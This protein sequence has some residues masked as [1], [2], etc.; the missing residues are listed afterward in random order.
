MKKL[1]FL[2][3]LLITTVLISCKRDEK[4][5]WDVDVSAPIANTKLSIAN[6][7]ADSLMTVN[8]DH[9]VNICYNDTLNTM[10]FGSVFHLPDTTIR[11]NL[12]S[13][14]WTDVY[15]GQMMFYKRDKVKFKIS[16]ASVSTVNVRSGKIVYTIVSTLKQK[17]KLTYQ[18]T[19]ASKNGKLLNFTTYLLPNGSNTGS[20]ISGELDLSDYSFNFTG[21]G[22]STNQL[23]NLITASNDSASN[24]FEITPEDSIS[25]FITFKDVIPN[26]A[27][28]YFGQI[29]DFSGA[30]STDLSVFK[31]IIA[32]NIRVSDIKLSLK[33]VNYLGVDAR[34]IL[35][36]LISDN[37]RTGVSAPLN[38]S[39]IGK[40]INISRATDP[41]NNASSVLPQ[42]TT[43]NIEGA[44]AKEFIDN[45]PD[46]IRYDVNFM[47]NPLGNVS[48]GND[49]IYYGK[50]FYIT[51]DLTM[52]LMLSSNNLTIADTI[53]FKNNETTFNNIN[54][55]M[56]YLIAHNTFPIDAS[57]QM[58]L[59][60]A[61]YHVIENIT[62]PNTI[63]AAN[64]GTCHSC[65]IP[66]KSVLSISMNEQRLAYL[67]RTK[68]FA[69]KAAFTTKPNAQPVKIYDD[70][71][72]E[73][74]ISTNAS[75]R[76]N[77]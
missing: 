19:S 44:A 77:E 10:D 59:L 42:T 54:G 24:K 50:G 30:K 2:F 58:Q 52:P 69:F 7:V 29:T 21:D 39:V 66:R 49:F 74:N 5:S 18:I 36:S 73:L 61:N 40:Y 14:F 28:G 22:T 35:N 31:K 3:F 33:V 6:F 17:T 20:R 16:N 25:I 38:S 9:S 43:V 51:M 46:K 71:Y 53:D 75:Y 8:T 76:I 67:K 70:A 72:L 60:D 64:V 45:L 56:L 4:T 23:N 13:P 15:P 11:T 48:G 57:I 62:F 37:S 68:Y 26:Y 47:M 41:M 63:Q 55:G 12:I 32:G 27:K 65:V 1:N 34:V